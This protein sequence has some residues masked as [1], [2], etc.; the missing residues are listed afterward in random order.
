MC[1]EHKTKISKCID[2]T[3]TSVNEDEDEMIANKNEEENI[4]S[5]LDSNKTSEEELDETKDTKSTSK[6][7]GK[8]R[9]T[10]AKRKI[11]VNLRNIK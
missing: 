10:K 1:P 9:K 2:D 4:K 11:R 7:R 3:N 8:P 6:M 5:D